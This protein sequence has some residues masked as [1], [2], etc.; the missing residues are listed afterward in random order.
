MNRSLGGC[1]YHVAHP[2]GLNYTTFPVNA[3]E[4]ESAAPG[5]L[6]PH[7][8]HARERCCCTAKRRTP[9]FRTRSICAARHRR[10]ERS[11]FR[12]HA[13]S[14][15]RRLRR[16]R[17]SLRRAA[18]GA[19]AAAAALGRVRACAR[20]ARASAR[21]ATRSRSTERQ[22]REH[23]I[24]YN[25][26]ADAQ[27]E[28]RPWEV[29]PI[30]LVLPADEW[31]T[32]AA[33]IEQRAD[34][35]NRVL[36]DLYGAQTLMKSGAIPP[37]V[38]FGHRGFLSRRR[39]AEAGRRPA[40]AAV[41]RRPGA[42]ARRPL[43]GRRRPHPGAVGVGLRAREPARRLARLS[44]DVP[45]AAGAAPGVVLRR[46]A[47]VAAPL[48]AARRRADRGSS[49]SRPGPTTRPT[50]STR[51]WRAISASPWSK[52]ATSRCATTASG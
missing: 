19:G 39:R 46:L 37:Q 16:A 5:A 35:L 33:G 42:L 45:R 51:S 32:I 13:G 25:V 41:R 43:V 27:G 29:D 17:G 24:T 9:T 30:P 12:A 38:I 48:G 10:T 26:Y 40:S 8:P 3:Y 49:C 50:S 1:Q 47:D 23:G 7:R 15:A 14:T 21:S 18:R 20:R 6:L 31:Q 2:G 28:H 52:A 44:A 36:G 34:L 4:A 22:I 11:I